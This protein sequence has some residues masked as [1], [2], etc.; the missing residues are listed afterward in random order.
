[1]GKTHTILWKERRFR[2]SCIKKPL[3]TFH[4]FHGQNSSSSYIA[5]QLLGW[6]T[7]K[8]QNYWPTHVQGFGWVFWVKIEKKNLGVIPTTAQ[9]NMVRIHLRLQP[10]NFYQSKRQNAWCTTCWWKNIQHKDTAL[11]RCGDLQKVP[12]EVAEGAVWGRRMYQVKP[13]LRIFNS[14]APRGTDGS[15][16]LPHKNL[17]L[18]AELIHS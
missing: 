2:D 17:A 18:K 13:R 16:C 9:Q 8:A 11:R 6:L 14:F 15:C 4:C 5:F 12:Y 1:M 10:A 7:D 3:S